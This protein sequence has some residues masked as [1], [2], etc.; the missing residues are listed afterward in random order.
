MIFD[1][2]HL[3]VFKVVLRED[4]LTPVEGSLGFPEVLSWFVLAYYVRDRVIN[5]L[6]FCLYSVVYES[7]RDEDVSQGV[8]IF[9][10]A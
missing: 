3:I 2:V 7:L 4:V 5:E 6:L 1:V 8:V 9:V 10:L